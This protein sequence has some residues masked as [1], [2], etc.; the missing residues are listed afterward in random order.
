[1]RWA[2]RS[3]LA[4]IADRASHCRCQ[5]GGYHADEGRCD[6]VRVALKVWLGRINASV[7][8]HVYDFVYRPLTLLWTP[9]SVRALAG[10]L[11]LL[12][13]FKRNGLEAGERNDAVAITLIGGTFGARSS[14]KRPSAAKT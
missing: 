12:G 6:H 13:S 2:G 8:R 1:M 4:W 5:G 14:P 7:F 11:V 3:S 10:F 9:H